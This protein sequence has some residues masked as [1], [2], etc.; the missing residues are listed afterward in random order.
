MTD[1]LLFKLDLTPDQDS[2]TLQ[3]NRSEYTRVDL[4]GGVGRYRRDIVGASAKIAVKWSYLDSDDYT[5]ICSFYRTFINTMQPFKMDLIIEDE[6]L[7]EC[8][9]R[10][11]PDTFRLPKVKA[12][13]YTVQATLEVEIPEYDPEID[14]SY[15][16][17]RDALGKNWKK[18]LDKLQVIT[19]D[20]LP[21]ALPYGRDLKNG[22]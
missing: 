21:K 18:W 19:N 16:F 11:F 2:Y 13:T 3:R 15:I 6:G 22:Y 9:C 12:V 20:D 4:D 5:Y 8:I 7:V 17:F 1:D 14:Y 10:I